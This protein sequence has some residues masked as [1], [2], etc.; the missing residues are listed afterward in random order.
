MSGEKILIIDIFRCFNIIWRKKLAIL[1][2]GLLFFSIALAA[3]INGMPNLYSASTTV[4][5]VFDPGIDLFQA[6]YSGAV[7]RSYTDVINSMK[8]LNSAASLLNINGITGQDLQDIISVKAA[9]NSSVITIEALSD[10]PV[11]SIS[12]ANAVANAFVQELTVISG[13]EIAKQLDVASQCE[14]ARDGMV[15]TWLIRIVSAVA[16]VLIACLVILFQD[17][18]S[19][20]VHFIQDATFNGS[21][22]V[23]SM[24]PDCKFKRRID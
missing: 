12:A 17:I 13:Q 1:L 8:V 5:S 4:C 15:F 7:L 16:T 9:D 11:I 19:T 3:T 20:K 6:Q 18:F 22:D 24:V 23:I 10:D 14:V 21:L 2:V